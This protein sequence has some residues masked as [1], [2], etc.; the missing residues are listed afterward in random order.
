MDTAGP[1]PPEP[2]QTKKKPKPRFKPA[3]P[4]GGSN[5]K[6]KDVRNDLLLLVEKGHTKTTAAHILGISPRSLFRWLKLGK[7]S[8]DDYYVSF[9]ADF[10]TARSRYIDRNLAILNKAAKGYTVKVRKE[11]EELRKFK[12]KG[13]DGKTLRDPETGEILYDERWVVVA[14]EVVRRKEF[15]PDMAKYA[16][17][18]KEREEWGSERL[19]I[20]ALKKEIQKLV[21]RYEELVKPKVDE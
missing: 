21:K 1:T 5:A 2:K 8:E 15:L 4:K 3:R 11:Q 18:C 7:D 9:V 12:R 14:R 16:L 17:Q 13:A 19:E 20:A 6:L 10:A